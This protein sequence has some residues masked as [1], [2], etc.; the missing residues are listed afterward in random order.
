MRDPRMFTRSLV[1]AQT[2]STAI[3]LIIAVVVYVYC[4]SYVASPALGSA[5][6]LIKRIAY[7]LALPGLAV[8]TTLFIHV[9]HIAICNTAIL[10][11]DEPKLP[12]KY[13]LVRMLRGS[14]HL[15]T[16]SLV[17]WSTWL[18]CTF[19]VAIAS[20]LIASGIP[21][22]G[23]LVSLIGA[24]FNAILAMQP[25][26]A[27][28]LYDNWKTEPH[29]RDWK[30]MILAAWA[31]ILIVGGTFITISGTYGAIV[32]IIDGLKESSGVAPWTC[33]DNSI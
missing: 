20:Y 29:S 23:G 3:Y 22:F 14:K 24:L 12:A 8:T 1:L 4:G 33:E 5:G 18:S 30:W 28:W 11:T 13:L 6:P 7:G 9:S 2:G 17:H 16:N 32:G 19:G 27:M 26:G 31:I 15:T 25:A 10:K 21:I